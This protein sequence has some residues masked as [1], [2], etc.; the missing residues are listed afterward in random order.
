MYAFHVEQALTFV[1]VSR[2][3][4]CLHLH[5]FLRAEQGDSSGG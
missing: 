4:D 3:T 5:P 2:S 1:G